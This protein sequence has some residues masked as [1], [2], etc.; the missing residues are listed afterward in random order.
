M[1][2][3]LEGKKLRDWVSQWQEDMVSRCHQGWM[4]ALPSPALWWVSSGRWWPVS[5]R[6]PLSLSRPCR[7]AW[8][9]PRRCQDERRRRETDGEMSLR[10]RPCSGNR[11]CVKPLRRTAWLTARNSNPGD[12][13]L[14][15][16]CVIESGLCVTKE[17][18]QQQKAGL[19]SRAEGQIQI[20]P[21]CRLSLLIDEDS[22]WRD[23]KFPPQSSS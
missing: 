19:E 2:V 16:Q 11:R 8:R 5:R 14:K 20:S 7:V 17:K 23:I 4:K 21:W 6:W 22:M 13:F 12:S 15:V 9:A 3:V 1:R 10:E 18:Q